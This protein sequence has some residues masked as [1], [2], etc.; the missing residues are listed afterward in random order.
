[1][2]VEL[3]VTALV[4]ALIGVGIFAGLTGAS[5][6][7]KNARNRSIAAALAQQDQERMRSY[8]ATSLSNYT[9][10]NN[11]PIA[12]T[13]F[14]VASRARWVADSS[15]ATSCT[16]GSTTANYMNITSTVTWP[17]MGGLKPVK[18]SSLVAPA[19]NS[20]AA[21][22]GSLTVRIRGGAG[23]GIADLPVTLGAPANL[24]ENTDSG[25]C[26]VFGGATA[27]TYNVSFSKPG[28]IDPNGDNAI[29]KPASVIGSTSTLLDVFYDQPG[30]IAAS[31]DTR[32]GSL[33]PP[34]AA[35]AHSISV[36]N[37]GPPS[38][39]RTF[40][41]SNPPQSTINATNLFPF[42]TAYGVYA[43]N[44]VNNDPAA[45]GQSAASVT[46]SS[47][48]NH[49]ATVR[50][51]ALRIL[52]RNSLSVPI[53]GARVVVKATSSGCTSQTYADQFTDALGAMPN[54]GHPYGS[55]S[56]CAQTTISGTVRRQTENMTNNSP[57]GT[58][59][60]TITL[61]SSDSSGPCT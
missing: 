52:V 51:P 18:T 24:T 34:Q 17:N 19:A 25:G 28:F 44:C 10:S 16:N 20:F 47:G 4:V 56:V 2:I 30:S 31:F 53:A 36:R 43:G 50:V 39:I 23:N 27:G 54:P 61:S 60:Q 22:Q 38:V 49:T 55:Y 11:Y 15:G 6:G 59:V 7:S 37:P 58:S 48:G 21:N 45:Y 5:S 12:G 8:K 26:A 33:V 13:T 9:A 32:L 46:V 40:N 14:T 1:M 35:Q 41:G 3:C 29:T 57:N 42:S